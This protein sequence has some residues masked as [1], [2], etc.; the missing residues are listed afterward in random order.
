MPEIIKKRLEA[1]CFGPRS[2][3]VYGGAYHLVVRFGDHIKPR[4]ILEGINNAISNAAFFTPEVSVGKVARNYCHL[5]LVDPA[6]MEMYCGMR[7]L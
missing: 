1:E 2:I 6:L 3:E 7:F 5:L 4:D